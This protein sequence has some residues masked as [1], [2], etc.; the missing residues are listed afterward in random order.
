MN[1]QQAARAELARRELARRESPNSLQ[2]S[3]GQE[4][5]PKPEAVNPVF[6]S[7]GKS[8]ES[9]SKPPTLLETAS[10]GLS[11][12]VRMANTV[13]GGAYENTKQNLTDQL[14]LVF[15]KTPLRR[16]GTNL[17][18]DVAAGLAIPSGAKAGASGVVRRLEGQA[19][20]RLEKAGDIL[21][22]ILRPG[23]EATP[24]IISQ[25]LPEVSKSR[26]IRDLLS[27]L[28][29]AKKVAGT[30]KGNLIESLEG[31]K[32]LS[33]LFNKP[34][35]FLSKKR[36]EGVLT[37]EKLKPLSDAI[38]H[39][40]ELV[41]NMPAD[42]L[43]PQFFDKRKQVFQDYA[44][45]IY[46]KDVSPESQLLKQAWKEI[47]SDYRSIVE[48]FDPRVAPANLRFKGLAEA[49]D[50]LKRRVQQSIE[51]STKFD[52][53]PIRQLIESGISRLPFIREVIYGRRGFEKVLQEEPLNIPFMTGKIEK[54][55]KKRPVHENI[56]KGAKLLAEG[57]TPFSTLGSLIRRRKS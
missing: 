37:D 35:S 47:A 16:L 43:T 22:R 34:L 26:T 7:L 31:T 3:L 53:P 42:K 21:T 12:A 45:K 30:E 40:M 18:I 17:G 2:L 39:E 1:P 51:K 24:E 20:K 52:K 36:G 5:A 50:V 38:D 23:T 33:Q 6:S 54:L 8:I 15:T 14:P 46:G 9:L 41:R 55:M 27:K 57:E 10:S 48:S 56:L 13:L 25:T 44:E 19:T 49:T 29:R 28:L 11:P 32:D 4:R